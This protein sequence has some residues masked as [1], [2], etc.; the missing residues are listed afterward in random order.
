MSDDDFDALTAPDFDRIVAPLYAG[1][2]YSPNLRTKNH[3]C[4]RCA[5]QGEGRI[6]CPNNKERQ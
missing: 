2:T 5:W 6:D 4:G 3:K 1:L